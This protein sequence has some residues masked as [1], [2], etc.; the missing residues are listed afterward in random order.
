MNEVGLPKAEL[1]TPSLWV[2][3]ETME[4]NV[5]VLAQHFSSAGVNWR[6]HM[7]GI[8]VPAIAHKALAAGAIG[9]TCAKLGEAEV[10]A[11]AGITNI[12][13]ANQ[14][15]G[16][17]K[18]QRLVQLARTVDIK[19]AVDSV[20]N[21]Q[22]IGQAA[23]AIGVQIGILVDVD[24]GMH[25]TGVTPGHTV[26]ALAQL[27]EQTPGL[28]FSGLMAWEGH[29]LVHS[30]LA[31]KEQAI[32]TAI[33]QLTRSAAHCR[34]AG[35]EVNIISGGGSGTYKITPF[36]GDMT[37]IQ[38]GGAIFSDVAYENWGVETTQC[39]F[40]RSIVTSRPT[41]ERI[42]IDAGF[43]AL[44]IWHAQPRP[45]GI[46]NIKSYSTS[47]E[48]GI[49]TLHVPNTEIKVGDAFDI[50]VGYTDST[51]FLHDQLYGLR[52]GVV[53]VVWQIAGR[54]RLR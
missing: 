21:A 44:P 2:D 43:K 29:T 35:L 1:D 49:I 24:T 36:L 30:D 18:I 39:L 17:R 13:I 11:A 33:E 12:L 5:A 48:H 19:V 52:D 41:P 20:S 23:S 25:R 40:V 9:I 37:E 28:C 31:A 15:V 38:A 22:A 42:V 14:V 32:N 3:L 51:L 34:D 6:P 10:M 46:A 26:V 53:E 47:A 54:G 45:I 7:K 8:K 4:Q 27:V 50:I 16:F